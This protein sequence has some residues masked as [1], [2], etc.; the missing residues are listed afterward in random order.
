M[1]WHVDNII[2]MYCSGAGGGGR[3]RP[4]HAQRLKTQTIVCGI[5]INNGLDWIGPDGL[6]YE[7]YC[8]LIR[9]MKCLYIVFCPIASEIDWVPTHNWLF[10][11]GAILFVS[12]ICTA[13]HN[14][15]HYEDGHDADDDINQ[16][17][18]F[19]NESECVC[20]I[21]GLLLY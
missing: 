9:I 21:Y 19:I 2:N 16:N 17:E 20:R 11:V 18:K 1:W 5:F 4:M 3:P 14:H 8:A 6:T 10:H 15:N 7:I 12:H 13:R